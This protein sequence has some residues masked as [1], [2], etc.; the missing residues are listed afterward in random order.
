M[1]NFQDEGFMRR[2]LELATQAGAMGEV[3]VGAVIVH[4]NQVIAEGYNLRE[5]A[6]E[7]LAHAE[8]KAIEAANKKLDRWRLEG[9]TLYVTLE[10]CVMC[11]GAIVQSRLDRVVYGAS[12]PKGGGVE[13]L[14]QI[15]A[16]SRLNH[17]PLVE[18]GLLKEACGKILSDFFSQR[19]QQG[20]Q[21][22]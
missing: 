20:N 6:K 9:C 4:N 11:A 13:S 16:D 2:A 5:S 12:D 7:A 19:R 3:P 14:Y 21:N 15:L 10:P 8:I 17:R 1:P 22:S 18:G